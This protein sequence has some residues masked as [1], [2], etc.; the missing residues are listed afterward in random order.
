MGLRFGSVLEMAE[1]ARCR[2]LAAV[3]G[4]DCAVQSGVVTLA[5]VR[6]R[7]GISQ[8]ELATSLTAVNS[9]ATVASEI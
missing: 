1:K 4:C 7:Y 6:C 9:P 2:G 5:E 8:A 3:E